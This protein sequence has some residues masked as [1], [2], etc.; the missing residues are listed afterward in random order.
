MKVL[1][2]GSGAREHALVWKLATSP[3]VTKVYCSPGNAGIAQQA[4][5]LNVDASNPL[6]LAEIADKEEIDLTVVGPEAPLVAG[7]V[8]AFSRRKRRIVGPTKAAAQLEGSKIFA[9]EFMARHHIPTADFTYCET[10][11]SAFDIISSG[12]YRFPVVLKADGLAAGKGVVIAQDAEEAFATI[13]RFM[14]DKSL[15]SAGTRLVIEEYL[16]GQEASLLVFSDGKDIL[17]MPLAQDYKAAYEGNRG[18]NTGGMEHTLPQE[19]Y[20]TSS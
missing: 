13:R 5:L 17:P 15:G 16:S 10:P 14:I 20:P 12:V 11:E 19:C 9:K 1:V 2:I 6:Q 8:D 18:P 3:N 7:I 4:T